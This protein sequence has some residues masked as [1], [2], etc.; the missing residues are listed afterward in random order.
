MPKFQ[1]KPT[2][3]ILPLALLS[4]CSLVKYQPI[5]DIDAVD[6]KQSYRFETNKLQREGD[7]DILIVVMPSGGGARAVALGCG[8][9]EQLNQQQVAIGGKR[10]S[11]LANI[12]IV[13]GVSG[14]SAL[15]AYFALKSKDTVSL[16][17]KRFLH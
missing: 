7:D 14:G 4:A 15:A 6:S 13:V 9:L 10:K 11:L 8:V 17:Y 2:L 5:A 1:L 12:D 16:F 3:S